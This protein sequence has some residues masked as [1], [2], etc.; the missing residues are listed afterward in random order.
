MWPIANKYK[1]INKMQNVY[2]IEEKIIDLSEDIRW[3]SST[4]RGAMLFIMHIST[5]YFRFV[6]QSCV[7]YCRFH[8]LKALIY[9]E[10]NMLHIKCQFISKKQCT[11]GSQLTPLIHSQLSLALTHW[12]RVTHICV[13]KLTTIAS[14]N[15]LSPGR[16]QSIISTNA[17]ILLIGPL[18]TNFSEILIGI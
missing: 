3:N 12:G 10:N 15:G 11:S 8:T 18:G 4:G 2:V 9:Y 13:G 14:D 5:P 16:R 7:S 6:W 17:G 1:K